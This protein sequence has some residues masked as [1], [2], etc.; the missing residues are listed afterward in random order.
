MAT[1]KAE[2]L[3]HHHDLHGVPV[4]S[5]VFAGARTLNRLGSATAPL[6]NLPGRIPLLRTLL[7]R[8]LGITPHRPLPAFARGN[9]VRWS[10]RRNRTVR[11]AP[12][13]QLTFLA[14]SFTTYTE[15]DIGRA[16]VELLEH[17]GWEVRLESGGCCGRAALSKGLADVAKNQARTLAHR[18]WAS[19]P[20]GSPVV[21]CEPSCL[22]TLRDEHLA[23]H[24]DDPVVKDLAGRVRQVEELL[25]DAIADGRLRLR[26]DSWPAGRRLLYH[27]HCHQKA[28]VGTEATVA[29]LRSVPGAEVT[30]PDAGCCGMAGSFGYESE[31]YELSMTV[32]ADRLFPAVE[33]QPDDTVI[34]A[35][36]TSCRQQILHGTG[37]RAWHPLEVVRAAL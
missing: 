17:C 15:P 16:A 28:E 21:G 13:G 22:M 8:A 4:R 36:G 26:A 5:R 6:S 24:P 31:H 35:T 2:T 9:L 29:L 27:G 18:I 23:M 37:R 30:E 20:P 3:A 1:L 7:D 14:D 34:V 32:G 12:Q 25:L 33:A 19:S 11:P 10:R